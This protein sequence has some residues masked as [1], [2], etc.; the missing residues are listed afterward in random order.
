M[1]KLEEYMEGIV[2]VFHQ[3]SLKVGH[4]DTLSM[5]ELGQLVTQEMPNVLKQSKDQSSIDKIFQDLDKDEN[6]AIGFNE[7]VK[8]VSTG[9]KT[10]HEN[11]HKTC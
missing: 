8:L 7:F 10:A 6:G 11:L 5:D 2:N 9:L 1:T 4:A 3:Y